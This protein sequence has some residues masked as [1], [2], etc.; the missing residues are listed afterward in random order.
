[1]I[2]PDDLLLADALIESI[3]SST[4]PSGIIR[5]LSTKYRASFTVIMYKLLQHKKI[6]DKQY[7][8][9]QLFFDKVLLP[10]YKVKID[11]D[12]EIKL[13]KAYHIGKDVKRASQSLSREVLAKH[14][15]GALTY[16]QVAKLLG[17]KAR[18]IEDIKS[19]VGFGQ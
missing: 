16:S 10:K 9:M 1:M 8:D 17:T 14:M 3:K 18:Y 4:D 7:K 5:I 11:P 6:T 19:A 13:G 15:S 12:K 2:L